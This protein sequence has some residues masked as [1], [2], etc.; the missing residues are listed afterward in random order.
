[1]G[2]TIT[3]GDGMTHDKS[4]WG[5]AYDPNCMC[6]KCHRTWELLVM[7]GDSVT[8]NGWIQDMNELS[9]DSR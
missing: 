3:K 8:I 5:K 6:E 4:K 9:N 7:A 1:M 2:R